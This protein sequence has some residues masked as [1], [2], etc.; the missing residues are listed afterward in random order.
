MVSSGTL[1]WK[2]STPRDSQK[3]C[4][5]PQYITHN[6]SSAVSKLPER[7]RLCSPVSSSEFQFP[8]ASNWSPQP[9][10][11]TTSI[12]HVIQGPKGIIWSSQL[13]LGIKSLDPKGENGRKVDQ[14]GQASRLIGSNA[15]VFGPKKNTSQK[16]SSSQIHE[17]PTRY[18]KHVW[19]KNPHLTEFLKHF[20]W[21]LFVSFMDQGWAP[22]PKMCFMVVFTHPSSLGSSVI[23]NVTR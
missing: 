10:H 9:Q 15:L 3:V 5:G 18:K 2:T 6:I 20:Y 7:L 21:D 22:A 13:L 11:E 23:R 16:W 17:S 14:I 8:R 4:Q 12:N 1:Q 19:T